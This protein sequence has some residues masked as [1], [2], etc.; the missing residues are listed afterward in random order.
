MKMKIERNDPCPC[1]SGK[2]YKKCCLNKQMNTAPEELPIH[3]TLISG[4]YGSRVVIISR[5]MP[6]GNVQYISVLVDGWKMGLKGCFG[7]RNISK[8]RFY[9]EVVGD[10]NAE[11]IEG[12]LYECKWVIKQGLR[13][14]EAVGTK[15][16]E[17]FYEFKD[18]VGSLDNINITGSLYKCYKCGKG[19]LS[20]KYVDSIKKI[21]YHDM[22]RGVCGTPDETAMFFVCDECKSKSGDEEGDEEKDEELEDFENMK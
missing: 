13:I 18:I 9:K 1:G 3:K 10:M 21:T 8:G 20:D 17:E 15:M 22:A 12:N 2:K 16:P 4:S 14:A 6:N 5:E 7:S 19:E 11:L